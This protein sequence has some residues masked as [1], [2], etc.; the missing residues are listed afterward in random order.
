M[1]KK[2]YCSASSVGN[3]DGFSS[4]GV[5]V[6]TVTVALLLSFYVKVFYVMSKM[7]SDEL[8]CMQTGLVMTIMVVILNVPVF[9]ISRHIQSNFSGSNTFGT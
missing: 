8:S 4:S 2:R 9:T 5:G 3:G 7:L 6:L 1:Y